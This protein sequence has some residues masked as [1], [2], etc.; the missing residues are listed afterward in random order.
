MATS[1]KALMIV[2]F[3]NLMLVLGNMSAYYINPTGSNSLVN[4][5]ITPLGTYG[6][7]GQ[8][9]Y[10]QTMTNASQYLASGQVSVETTSAGGSTDLWV[11]M[12]N[13]V[14]NTVPG[15]N[16][17]MS[18]IGAPVGFLVS[19]GIPSEFAS[20]IGGVWWAITIIIIVNWVRGITE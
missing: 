2:L 15:L 4:C 16:F 5:S 20:V 17:L 12:K 6:K 8:G 11:T 3:V 1:T 10:T 19:I 18:I 7:C 14:I 9:T 13:W